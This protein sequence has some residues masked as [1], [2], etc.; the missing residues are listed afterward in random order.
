[1]KTMPVST[2]GAMPWASWTAPLG[3]RMQE[4]LRRAD[5]LIGKCVTVDSPVAGV[6][7]SLRLEVIPAAID[8][9]RE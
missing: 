9:T 1:M 6:E 2:D 8:V 7:G 3:I 5:T 4:S